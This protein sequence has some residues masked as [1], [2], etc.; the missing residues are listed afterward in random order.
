M[1]F[2]KTALITNLGTTGEPIFK[3]LETAVSEG[4]IT[5]FLAYGRKIQDQEKPPL[6]IAEQ[7]EEKAKQLGVDCLMYELET[8]EDF[9]GSFAF[10]QQLMET[11]S[12]YKPERVIIDVTGGTKV[13]S[14]ALIHAALT[15]QWS[16]DVIFEYVGG[17]RDNNGRVK[18]ME[19]KRD[20]GIVTQER[21]ITVLDSIRQQEFARARFI[22]VNLPL[23]EKAGFLR[24]A[25]DIFWQWDNFHYDETV[26]S[27]ES[28]SARAQELVGD[29]Q[30][31]KV[32]DTVMRLEKVAG[33]IKLA[34]GALRQLKDKGGSAINRDMMAGWL[35]ILGDTIANARRRAESDPVDCVLRCYRVVEI[36]E[37]MVVLSLGTNPWKP[38]WNELGEEKLKVY[39][40]MIH[41]QQ[42]PRQ[43]SLD[44]GIKLIETLSTPIPKDVER[45]I[46]DIQSAR[47]HCYLEHGYDKVVKRT[48][49]SLMTKMENATTVLLARA[50]IQNNPFIIADQLRIEA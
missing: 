37:Q 28:I 42:P 23:H 9:D 25:V 10:Y 2:I 40:S 17:Q 15:L 47:N 1:P 20:S 19:L 32:A 33:A 11:V 29:N 43:V 4:G 26:K 44:L 34:I 14:A 16:A 45:D 41:A 30:L 46:R 22:A 8:P 18:E 49:L 24:K 35:D 27:L 13:M 21:M 39:L 38:D 36:A 50:D 6:A 31:R 12:G 7:I 5:L 48:A 3:A